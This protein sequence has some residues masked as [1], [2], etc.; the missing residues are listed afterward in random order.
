M[1]KE[2]DPGLIYT[3]KGVYKIVILTFVCYSVLL[4]FAFYVLNK[5]IEDL[6][7][8]VDIIKRNQFNVKFYCTTP[9]VYDVTKNIYV[10]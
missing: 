7:K 5:R 8:E 6:N 1:Q 9:T 10:L 3:I 4:L 2:S